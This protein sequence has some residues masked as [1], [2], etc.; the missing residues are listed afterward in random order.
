[1]YG[2]MIYPSFFQIVAFIFILILIITG[3][4]IITTKK[5]ELIKYVSKIDSNGI[6]MIIF[7]IIVVALAVYYFS[8]YIFYEFYYYFVNFSRI[9]EII[10]VFLIFYHVRK[11]KRENSTMSKNN[12]KNA[13]LSKTIKERNYSQGSHDIRDFNAKKDTCLNCGEKIEKNAL[14]CHNCGKALYSE[15]R[16][17]PYCGTF[18]LK[19][20]VFC[21]NCGNKLKKQDMCTNQ[22]ADVCAK[23]KEKN[24]N[25]YCP[26]CGNN[27]K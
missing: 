12:T 15:I 13:D 2:I 8:P 3:F 23:N 27:F 20:G 18:R 11:E 4:L 26:Y 22:I 9:W 1:M 21:I 5:E 14:F 6:L 19:N 7:V 10:F 24:D 25:I 17:C 16:F